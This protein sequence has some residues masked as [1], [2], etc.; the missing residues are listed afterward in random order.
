LESRLAL[1]WLVHERGYEVI[2]LSMN[3]GQGV[4]LEPLGELACELGAASAQVVDRRLEFV[5]DFAL[6]VL[7]AGALY[8][9]NCFLGSALARYVVAREL[10]RVGRDEG[11]DSVAH[12][13][14]SR[15]NDQVRMETAIAALA[16]ELRVL[17]PVREWNLKSVEDKWNFAR[18]WRIP[19]EE[20]T[21]RTVRVDRNLWG[22]STYVEGLNDPWD[23]APEKVFTITQDPEQAPSDPE[24]CA[25][26]FETGTPTH[27]N[28]QKMDL[29]SLVRALNHLGGKH[30]I[31]R[32]DVVEDL[33]FGLKSREF[34][35]A[36]TPTLLLTAHRSL[37]ALVQSKELIQV[38][39]LLGSRYAELVYAGLWF[40]DLR[41]ALQG[42]FDQTQRYVTGEVR[43]KLYKGSCTV[44]GRRSPHSLYDGRLADQRNL[45]W[46]DSPWTKEMTSLWTLPSRLGA[47]R[48]S[49]PDADAGSRS[50]RK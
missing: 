49:P 45:E 11:C 7:Q 35:E 50:G 23:Q 20:V 24:T 18:R 48:Q 28:G 47:R 46:L 36:P 1:H 2:A 31:G 14:A 27:L 38:K 3:L 44:L 4:Y 41:H 22:N 16:P 6:P 32:R 5:R 34:Y 12:S 10:V 13:A 25:L 26:A 8:Q 21:D 33:L 42:F 17:A 30:G 19:I 37:E 43:L 9:A 29:L 40:N 39:E 15:G